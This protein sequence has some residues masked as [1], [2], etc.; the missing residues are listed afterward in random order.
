MENKNDFTQPLPRLPDNILKKY[1]QLTSPLVSL[2]S[3]MR[4][5]HL[6]SELKT[7]VSMKLETMK[8]GRGSKIYA[9]NNSTSFS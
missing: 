8:S 3:A 6:R 1:S 5:E 7:N 2:Q 9:L 4:Q